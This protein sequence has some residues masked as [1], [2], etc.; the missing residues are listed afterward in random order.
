MSTLS[1]SLKSWKVLLTIFNQ[2]S[3]RYIILFLLA[4]CGLNLL[5]QEANFSYQYTGKYSVGI[6]ARRFVNVLVKESTN[7]PEILFTKALPKAKFLRAGFTVQ[8]SSG[9][10]DYNSLNAGI[11]LH[12]VFH[13]SDKWRFYYGGDLI[14]QMNYQTN[15][16]AS[17]HNGS[18]LPFFGISYKISK[19]LELSTE[20]GIFFTYRHR[21]DPEAFAKLKDSML[22]G[23]A[24][25]GHIRLDFR[26]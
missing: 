24:N 9:D 16:S 10:K 5:S 4:F 26:F 13:N 8:L 7:S 2:Q 12:K 3:L 15:T 19:Y 1:K 21:L 14:Y 17:N 18:A 6:S 22:I 25:V 20:P 23:M 11:G